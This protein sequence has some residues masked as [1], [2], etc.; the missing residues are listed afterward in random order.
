ME[1]FRYNNADE[2][3][4]RLNRC[5]LISVGIVFSVLIFYHLMLLD[6]NAKMKSMI[7][8]VPL[9]LVF[10]AINIF[11]FMRNQTAKYY[12]FIL[13]AEMAYQFMFYLL[14]T[15]A[16]FLGL[17]LIGSL[18]VMIPYYEKKSYWYTFWAYMAVFIGGQVLRQVFS[19]VEGSTTG[20]CQVVMTVAVMIVLAILSNICKV[21]SDDAL[22]AVEEQKDEQAKMMEAILQISH[23]VKENS[24]SGTEMIDRLWE[25]A[26]NTTESMN[27]ITEAIEEAAGNIESQSGMT[28]NIQAAIKDAKERSGKMV[29]VAENSG[30]NV[31]DNQEMMNRLKQQ[32]AKI[33]EANAQVNEAMEKLQNQTA[34]VVKI[35]EI[36]V[37]I[38]NQTNLLA[39]NASIESARAGEAGRGFAVVADQIRLLSEETK[40][41]TESITAIINELDA[42]A[43]EVLESVK[44]SVEAAESQNEAI[45][46]A[47][48][49][50]ENLDRNIEMLLSDI[51]EIDVKIEHLSEANDRIVGSI[52]NL[53][54]TTEEVTAS[55]EQTNE[56][57]KNNLNYV[58]VAKKAIHEIQNSAAGL[59]KFF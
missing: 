25:S 17:I 18:A 58:E 13:A 37:G 50:V 9:I 54:G 55:A 47:A 3:M 27:N 49:S 53:M 36:I 34:E 19:V 24:D 28:R 7:W 41:S 31:R 43:K 4:K 32:A 57:S 8:N 30:Q 1:K 52:T 15:D 44:L 29:E 12:K 35:T 39:L 21:F 5:F 6:E 46:I 42:N 59:E 20:I 38:S 2:R 22:G 11:L 10:G 48:D 14:T 33:A 51:Q 26:V 23:T 16:T 45:V 56:N 40:S